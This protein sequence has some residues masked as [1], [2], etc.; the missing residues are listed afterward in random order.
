MEMKPTNASKVPAP[1]KLKPVPPAILNR[2]SPVPPVL[3]IIP[4]LLIVAEPDVLLTVRFA[5]KSMVP[6]LLI[7]PPLIR[8]AFAA[9]SIVP[10][11]LSV[12][13]K[14]LLRNKSLKINVALLLMESSPAISPPRKIK[15]PSLMLLPDEKVCVPPLI[16]NA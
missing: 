14:S 15:L 5:V 13:V 2:L 16:R 12:P 1:A 7:V 10:A 6:V 11:L 9:N 4:V 3:V 8:E